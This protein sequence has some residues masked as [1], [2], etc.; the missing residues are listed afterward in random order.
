MSWKGKTVE[1][2]RTEFVLSAS[3]CLNFSALCKEYDITRK[4]GYKW[5]NRFKSNESMSDKSKA[6]SN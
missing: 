4:T 6:P 5:F 2:L 1:E 3:N